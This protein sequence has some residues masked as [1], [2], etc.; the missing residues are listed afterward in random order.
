MVGDELLSPEACAH[1]APA[2]YEAPEKTVHSS[3][4]NAIIRILNFPIFFLIFNMPFLTKVCLFRINRYLKIGKEG[5]CMVHV[6]EFVNDLYINLAF[7]VSMARDVN[8]ILK[9]E[10]RDKK[11]CLTL[12]E[13]E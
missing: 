7:A 12:E 9:E 6:K 11:L 8:R 10:R 3:T 1:P 2:G 4:D 13:I 5:F